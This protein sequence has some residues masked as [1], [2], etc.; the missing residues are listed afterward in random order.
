MK[1]ERKII[2]VD[3]DSFFASVEM[4]YN[5]N[6]KG[7]AIAVGGSPESRGVIS[8]ASYEAR[9][10]GVKSGISS[11]RAM[12]ECPNLLIIPPDFSKYKKESLAI[13]EIFSRFTDLIEPLSLDE[14]F[15]DVTDSSDFKGSATL[16]AQEIRRLIFKERGLTASAGI[17]SNKFLAKIASDWNKPNG[18]YVISPDKITTFI[19]DVPI[20]K[21]FG[22]GRVT[23]GKMHKLGIRT[24][25]DLQKLSIYKLGT[26]FGVWGERLYELSRGI[27][28]RAVETERERKSLSVE[29]TFSYD[30]PDFDSCKKAFP[31]IYNE[32]TLRFNKVKEDYIVKS[33]FVKIK[34]SNFQTTTVEN[35]LYTV[36]S[37]ERFLDLLETAFARKKIPVRLIGAGVKIRDKT[38]LPKNIQLLLPLE[39]DN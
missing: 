39:F 6:L 2:H 18:Q 20:E 5:P 9:K 30:L 33:L 36:Y 17:S 21:I 13:N 29:E 11:Y 38:Y 16:I 22:V 3:M 34:F 37:M 23:A 25:L 27:D 14:A 24:C 10:F 26:L 35:H 19:K 1:K 7:K 31:S 12:K 4:L 32:F 8:T 28:N 15:L